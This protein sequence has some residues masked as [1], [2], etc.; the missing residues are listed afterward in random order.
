[1]FA[2]FCELYLGVPP[3]VALFRCFYS[4]RVTAG[5]QSSGCVSFRFNEAMAS[6]I[7][8]LEVKKKVEDF[9]KH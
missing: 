8:P 9:R 1:M 3:S 2:F 6:K 5:D 4:L 7:I